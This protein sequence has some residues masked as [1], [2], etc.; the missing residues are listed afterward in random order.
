MNSFSFP[1]PQFDPP[2]PPWQTLPTM[3]DLPSEDPEEPG[4]PDE[5]HDLQ[6]QLLSRTLRLNNYTI[7]QFFTG[8]DLNLYYDI[9]HPQWHKRPDWFLVVGV[10][11]LYAGQDLRRSYVI[12][13][14]RRNPFVVVELLSPGTQKEDL[15]SYAESEPNVSVSVQPQA[16]QEL[17]SPEVNN[18]KV[19]KDA[20]PS[21]WFVYEQL[22]RVP[23]YIVFSRYTNRVR[24]FQ[25]VGGQYQEQSLELENP[26]IWIPELGIGLGLWQGEFEGIPRI[27]LRWYDAQGN[28]MPTDT[29][30]E[31][32]QKEQ[33]LEQIEQERTQKEQA[34]QQVEQERVQKEQALQQVEQERAQKEQALEQLLQVARN[35]LKSGMPIAQISQCT[36]LPETELRKLEEL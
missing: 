5:F 35:L 29:E 21:K 34:L 16:S 3:Y 20:P 6:P 12:W 24:F 4:L 9:E 33:A 2:L 36:G 10:S 1:V 23:Y 22:L 15:G 13:Q 7:D 25:L 14:E 31:R 17:T 26:R 30:R 19:T 28:W 27:W 32:T 8:T 18:G 11:R